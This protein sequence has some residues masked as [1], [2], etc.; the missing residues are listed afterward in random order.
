ML[1]GGGGECVCVLSH[2]HCCLLLLPMLTWL[3]VCCGSFPPGHPGC[4]AQ[5]FA[6]TGL[7]KFKNASLSNTELIYIADTQNHAIRTITAVC[8]KVCTRE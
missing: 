5:F 4:R 7:G 3:C 2:S 6:P 1:C 8:S